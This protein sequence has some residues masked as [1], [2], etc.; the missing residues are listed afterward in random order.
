MRVK[1]DSPLVGKS[2]LDRSINQNYDVTVLDI[3]RQKKHIVN[4]IRRTI[5]KEGYTFCS[6][7]VRKFYTNER[8]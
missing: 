2:C 8:G 4:N 5:L 3:I 7:H 6:R 1:K